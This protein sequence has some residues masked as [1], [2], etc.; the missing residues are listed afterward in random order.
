LLVIPRT[1]THHRHPL[2]IATEDYHY[3]IVNFGLYSRQRGVLSSRTWSCANPQSPVHAVW[4]V[5]GTSF[6]VRTP[7]RR[8]ATLGGTR[9]R[10]LSRVENEKKKS[11]VQNFSKN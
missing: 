3:E 6:A 1:P 9:D 2:A 11:K 4:P 5:V 10:N 7:R 8:W